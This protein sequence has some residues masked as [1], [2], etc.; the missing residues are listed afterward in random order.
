MELQAWVPAGGD[1]LV[2]NVHRAIADYVAET[3][4]ERAWVL[5]E[6]VDGGR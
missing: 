1:E 2:E 4:I 5:V 6:L 3:G